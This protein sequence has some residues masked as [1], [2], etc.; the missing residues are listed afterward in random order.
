MRVVA[1]TGGIGSGKTF[2]ANIFSNMG[3]P[4]YYSDERTK[5]L[6]VTSTI[7]LDNLCEIL[8]DEIVVDGVL[9][10]GIMA[11]KIFGD[12]SLMAKVEAVVHPAV[13]DDFLTWKEEI[14]RSSGN[15]IPP[16]VLFESAIILEKPLVRAIADRVITL[17]APLDMRIERVIKRD[18]TTKEQVLARLEAQWSDEQRVALSDFVIF[19]DN[20]KAL[21]PQILNI[22]NEVE[23]I[24]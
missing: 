23:K 9:Q 5:Q 21:L 16:F 14:E 7:L 18:N 10:K 6:Y 17:T 3:I 4:V 2:V 11:S 24:N 12:S 13:I 20:K 8:G 15:N 22:I 19:A 1:C